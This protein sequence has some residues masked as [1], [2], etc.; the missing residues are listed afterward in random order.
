MS[1]S[2]I[3]SSY[4]LDTNPQG[5]QSRMQQFR[6]EFQQLG[7][8][9]QTGNLT[10]AQADFAT[11]QQIAPGSSA[12]STQSTNPI[13]KDFAQL[14]RDLQSGNLSAAQHDYGQV[15]KDMQNQAVHMR[16]HRHGG[17]NAA[18]QIGQEFDQL[19][20]ALQS[21]NLAAAQQAYSTLPQQLQQF[22]E[23]RAL[24]S[25]QSASNGSGISVK[26]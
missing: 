4:F 9:L 7:Q 23:G 10:A 17:G 21:G 6:K 20:Q 3:P 1:V 5:T 25:T 16:H 24:L 2:G 15:L 19:G 11:L 26:A 12:S 13:A 18:Q 14:A 8:D 22:A